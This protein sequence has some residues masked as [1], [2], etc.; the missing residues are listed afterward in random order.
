MKIII[1]LVIVGLFVAAC[2][3]KGTKGDPCWKCDKD[4]CTRCQHWKEMTGNDG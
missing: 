4:N 1:V 3:D 2:I